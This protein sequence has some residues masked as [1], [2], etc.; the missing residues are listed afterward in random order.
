[1]IKLNYIILIFYIKGEKQTVNKLVQ[2]LRETSKQ[3]NL[4]SIKLMNK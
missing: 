2:A 4:K 3:A 1:M